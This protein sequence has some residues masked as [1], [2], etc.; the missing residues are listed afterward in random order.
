MLDITATR[1]SLRGAAPDAA[2]MPRF[3]RRGGDA[4]HPLE[5]AARVG[6]ESGCP[7]AAG[8]PRGSRPDRHSHARGAGGVRRGRARCGERG[9]DL[10]ADLRGDRARRFRSRRQAGA[11]LEGVGAAAQPG[12]APPAEAMVRAPG[13]GPAVPAGALPHRAARR[14]RP[15]AA[16]QR[17]GGGHADAR[18]QE[19]RRLGDQRAQAVHLQRL[20]CRPLRGLRQQQSE[21]RHAAGHLVVPGAARRPRG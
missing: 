13:R 17:A 15:L 5:L 12:A 3:R 18:R 2:V 14:L 20:R 1:G 4:V 10:R 21:G 8:D 11:E 6:H 7:A 19:E 16:L 9:A